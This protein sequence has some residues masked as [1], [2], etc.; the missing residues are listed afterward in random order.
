MNCITLNNRHTACDG[1]C[2]DGTHPVCKE[3][4][5]ACRIQCGDESYRDKEHCYHC[6]EEDAI[7]DTCDGEGMCRV[8]RS[9]TDLEH[10]ECVNRQQE[11]VGAVARAIRE[12]GRHEECEGPMVHGCG[13]GS[14][15][16]G[17]ERTCGGTGC[18]TFTIEV[19]ERE[20][21]TKMF[22]RMETTSRIKE[23]QR[24]DGEDGREGAASSSASGSGSAVVDNDDND[25][26]ASL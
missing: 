18:G 14:G 21:V 20:R 2:G 12:T 11:A 22:V 19:D 8:C 10:G 17:G 23:R 13:T 1:K 5:G 9:D 7:C 4:D 25:C 15:E 24:R 6:G 16:G 3:E 26:G